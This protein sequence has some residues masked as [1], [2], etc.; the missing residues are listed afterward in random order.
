MYEIVVGNG[1]AGSHSSGLLTLFKFDKPGHLQ[2]HK[3]WETFFP[4]L[5]L[6]ILV[7][8]K[9]AF[10]FHLFLKYFGGCLI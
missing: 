5:F 4:H 9:R 2:L 8:I 1:A 7:N 6:G 10:I 3:P